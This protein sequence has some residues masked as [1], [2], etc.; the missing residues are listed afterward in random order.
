MSSGVGGSNALF[1][2][3]VP[4]FGHPVLTFGPARRFFARF[5]TLRS[6]RQ[7]ARKLVP[8]VAEALSPALARPL[9]AEALLRL[10]PGQAVVFDDQTRQK[11]HPMRQR[12]QPG[13][14][15]VRLGGLEAGQGPAQ[16]L[17]AEA[18]AGF[19]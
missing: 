1:D 12:C 7:S 6:G 8:S 16:R 3:F 11:E 4:L 2:D 15:I 18:H 10:L 14:G 9:W 5:W 17:F 19:N 13:P